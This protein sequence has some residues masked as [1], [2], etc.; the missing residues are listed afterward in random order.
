MIDTEQDDVLTGLHARDAL[1]EAVLWFEGFRESD[2]A[3]GELEAVAARLR[4]RRSLAQLP[5]Q[6]IPVTP[7][8]VQSRSRSQQAPGS[9]ST[10][11]QAHHHPAPTQGTQSPLKHAHSSPQRTH[12]PGQ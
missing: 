10:P 6:L 11:P 7:S 8:P 1:T 12:S 2:A 4:T 5:R 3:A 9:A